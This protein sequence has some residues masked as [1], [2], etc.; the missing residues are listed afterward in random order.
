MSEVPLMTGFPS[1]PSSRVTLVN[2]QDPPFNRWS[3]Q[4][5]RELIPTQRISR[6]QGPVRPLDSAEAPLDPAAVAVQ[7][8]DDRRSTL[9][10]VLAETWTDAVVIVHDGRV[11]LESYGNGMAPDT[12]HL[13]MSVTKS[14]VGCVAGVLMSRGLLDPSLPIDLYVPEIVG[15]GYSG[16]TTRDLLDM[17]TGVL[18]REEYTNPDSE[19]RQMESYMGWRPGLSPG[20][21]GGMYAFLASM[22]GAG[23]HGGSFVYRSADTD[24]LGWVCERAA[25]VRMA[26]LISDLVWRPIGAEFPAE[27][28][29]DGV[30]SAIHDGGM[31]ATARD[32]A[33]FGQMLLDD[34]SVAGVPVVPNPWLVQSRT[35]DPDIRGA[36]ASSASDATLTGGWY[37]NQF[38]YV[39]GPLGDLQVCLGIHGQ[40]VVI[41]RATKT[42]SV[43]MSSWPAAQTP[44]YLVDTLRAFAETG[45]FLAGLSGAAPAAGPLTG[46]IS[47]VKGRE[48]GDA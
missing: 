35:I 45:R 6:G 38:W 47:I 16:A 43:K 40:M 10:D 30:G 32:V 9:A 37:R 14:V 36:F 1:D 21:N 33:R 12:V 29:C 34:G 41:D 42:V 15:S 18:F 25:G 31:S 26:D 19:V 44:S 27:I 22:S 4:H 24:M 23:P 8:V 13:M 3:F 46:P 48:R 17:R 39:P 11:V 20:Y 28:T 7:R 5:L 2:W